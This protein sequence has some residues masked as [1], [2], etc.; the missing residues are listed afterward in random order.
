MAIN[1]EIVSIKDIIVKSVDPEK[2]YLFGSYAYGTPHKDS[3]YDFYV[4][5]KDDSPIKPF[6]AMDIIEQNLIGLRAP[7]DI[8]ANYKNRFEARSILPTMERK[9]VREGVLLYDQ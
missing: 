8:H 6:D 1:D 4:V 7:T 9:I 3:D 5:L 2:V